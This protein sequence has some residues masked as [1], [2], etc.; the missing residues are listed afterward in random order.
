MSKNNSEIATKIVDQLGKLE[1]TD[2]TGAKAWTFRF[3][4]FGIIHTIVDYKQDDELGPIAQ[5]VSK[6]DARE[7]AIAFVAAEIEEGN[8]VLADDWAENNLK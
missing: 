3:E 4:P 2:A 7:K 6:S 5:D 1:R 8:I